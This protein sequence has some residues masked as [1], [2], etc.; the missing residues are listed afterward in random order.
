MHAKYAPIKMNG[1]YRIEMFAQPLA[2]RADMTSNPRTKE[3]VSLEHR[4]D[5]TINKAIL[6]TIRTLIRIMT[7]V[8]D[9]QISKEVATRLTAV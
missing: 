3:H 5:T 2:M 1:T 4:L 6:E 9:D 8:S 7:L